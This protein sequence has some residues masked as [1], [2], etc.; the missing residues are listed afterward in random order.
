MCVLHVVGAAGGGWMFGS[1][2]AYD[3]VARDLADASDMIVVNVGYR[4][5]PEVKFPVPI[6]VSDSAL[7]SSLV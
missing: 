6:K 3:G 7:V 4:L 1:I 5:A 2:D